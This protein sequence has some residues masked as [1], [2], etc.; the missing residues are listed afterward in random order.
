MSNE[1]DLIR[2][3]KS[4]DHRAFEALYDHHY[5]PVYTYIYYR[6]GQRELAEDLTSDVFERMVSKIDSWQPGDKPFI[7]WLYT[8]AGNLVRND[9]KRHKRITWLSLEDHDSKNPL[10][11]ESEAGLMA[12]ISKSL[13]SQQIIQS[14]NKLTE[15]QRQVVILRFIQ[16]LPTAEVAQKL[17]KPE[18]SIKALQRRAIGALRR[19]LEVEGQHV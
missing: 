7:A 19:V 13:Q 17:G 2:Q 15:D 14:I 1:Q 6:V 8:I 4:G 12:Q 9:I 18:T 11:E 16:G 3:A 5:Q 10:A